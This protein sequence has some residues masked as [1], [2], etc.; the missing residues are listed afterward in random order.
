[1]IFKKKDKITHGWKWSEGYKRLET[2]QIVR[3]YPKAPSKKAQK[4][5]IW[6]ARKRDNVARAVLG[7]PPRRV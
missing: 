6:E 4:R 2:G 5:I 1:M 7:L 3:E